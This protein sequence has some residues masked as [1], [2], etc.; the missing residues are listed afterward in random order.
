MIP[1]PVDPDWSHEIKW[2]SANVANAVRTAMHI[3]SP[4]DA[5]SELA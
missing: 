5:F 1:P 3:A 4:L 2:I